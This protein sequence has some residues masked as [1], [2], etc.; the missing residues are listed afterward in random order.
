MEPRVDPIPRFLLAPGKKRLFIRDARRERG[1]APR[2]ALANLFICWVIICVSLLRQNTAQKA[3]ASRMS[4]AYFLS[5]TLDS[6]CENRKAVAFICSCWCRSR[7]AKIPGETEKAA[8]L[9]GETS[10]TKAGM[11]TRESERE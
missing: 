11:R 4:L 9:N 6:V 3:V 8:A 1:K 10:Y 5:H 7:C 2:R